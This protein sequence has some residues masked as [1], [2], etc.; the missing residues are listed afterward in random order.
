MFI[1]APSPAARLALA[2]TFLLA[3]AGAAVAL[4]ENWQELDHDELVDAV[5]SEG[6]NALADT[7]G[8]DDTERAQL[9]E[10]L[11]A[12]YLSDED[13]LSEH[14]SFAL[15][16]F[17]KAAAPMLDAEQR[18]ALE[19]QLRKIADDGEQVN[20]LGTWQ[21][22]RLRLVMRE[23]G[24]SEEAGAERAV[25]W[26][27]ES[28]AWH[29][30][31]PVHFAENLNSLYLIRQHV[32][33]GDARAKVAERARQHMLADPAWLESAR[34]R[35][36]R[37]MLALFKDEELA[38]EDQ[39]ALRPYL[40]ERLVEDRDVFLSHTVI[41][42]FDL[43]HTTGS[44]GVDDETRVTWLNDWVANSDR[45]QTGIARDR[46]TLATLLRLA[47][48]VG[49][50][51]EA[52]THVIDYL[53]ER[54]EHDEEWLAE[55]DAPDLRVIARNYERHLDANQRE[56]LAQAV[57]RRINMGPE[58]KG[59]YFD[60]V[61]IAQLFTTAD[62]KRLVEDEIEAPD[63]SAR[64]DAA[65][66]V[67]LVHKKLGQ[68]HAWRA[69]LDQQ[70]AQPELTADERTTWLLARS[71]AAFEDPPEQSDVSSIELVH[72]ALATAEGE[73]AR[74]SAVD[75]LLTMQVVM[76]D[77]DEAL[78]TVESLRP[79]FS[80]TEADE[81]FDRWHENLITWREAAEE[82][83]TDRLI[84]AREQTRLTLERRLEEARQRG[85]AEHIQRYEALLSQL[86]P[87]GE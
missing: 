63:G 9:A 80:G 47:G 44:L 40:V 69:F 5:A 87:A 78:S 15:I 79:Q 16:L 70:L 26:V 81:A 83:A 17:A 68:M 1:T 21:Q 84:Q 10:H 20:A 65:R 74:L 43:W 38:P 33:V 62:L 77:Y 24:E 28:D 64:L 23:L 42:F 29:D 2:I 41:R 53:A 35:V 55:L 36:L 3:P 4:P 58:L 6:R 54:P 73:A 34:P 19:Q 57:A 85:S 37:Q 60:F 56:G 8:F 59:T 14:G 27:L 86:E 52:R 61:R 22:W 82:R 49:D 48:E 75:W 39:D 13:Y 25:N 46:N 71:F 50:V 30:D 67:A 11:W 76:H 72:E 12:E 32:D 18:D 7:W 45:W 31:V 51:S 66:L